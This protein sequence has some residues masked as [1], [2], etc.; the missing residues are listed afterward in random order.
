VSVPALGVIAVDWVGLAE[1]IQVLRD[2]LAAARE[3]G[4]GEETVFAVG[5]IEV[6]FSVVAKRTGEGKAGLTFG[7]VTLGMSGG[8]GR[9]ETHRVKVTLMPR[10]AATGQPPEISDRVGSIPER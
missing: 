5:P 7:V 6:E 1:A 2:E 10:D 8:T 3:A 9:E 4:E